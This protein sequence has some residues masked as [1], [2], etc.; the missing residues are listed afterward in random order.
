IH[1]IVEGEGLF[2]IN[3]EVYHLGAKEGFI[4]PP[5]T[6]NNYYPLANKPWS[7]RW[8]GFKGNLCHYMFQ[9]CGLLTQTRKG[10]ENFTYY[11]DD[12]RKMGEYFKNVFI[13]SDEQKPYAALGEA[14]HLLNALME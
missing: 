13:F 1:Y 9:K 3:D 12:I 5:Y 8:I 7:Y 10:L 6:K 2:F 14:Y 4:I 11:Y